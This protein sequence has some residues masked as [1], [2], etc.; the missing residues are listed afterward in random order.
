MFEKVDVRVG[1]KVP[2][3]DLET[4]P[5]S[6]NTGL[7]HAFERAHSGIVGADSLES[8]ATE[9]LQRLA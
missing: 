9:K 8:T 1:D 4:H 6:A 7:Q 3:P 2:V 5:N